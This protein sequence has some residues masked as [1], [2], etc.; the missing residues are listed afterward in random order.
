MQSI[1]FWNVCLLIGADVYC[2]KGTFDHVIFCYTVRQFP[3]A[4]EKFE[5]AVD[6]TTSAQNL[7]N[8]AVALHLEGN[9]QDA[10]ANH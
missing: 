3:S 1:T 9:F 6:I 4:R 5:K 10:I 2:S 7:I 8:L